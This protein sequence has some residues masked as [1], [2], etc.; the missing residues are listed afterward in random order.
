[1]AFAIL[2]MRPMGAIGV[3]L[4]ARAHTC[5]SAVCEAVANPDLSKQ[6]D[7]DFIVCDAANLDRNNETAEQ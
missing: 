6:V 4:V 1:M 2:S 3:L 7:V 5:V